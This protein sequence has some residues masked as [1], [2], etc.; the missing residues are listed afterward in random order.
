M[1]H[2]PTIS[3]TASEHVKLI[4]FCFANR[5]SAQSTEQYNFK[6]DMEF[7]TDAVVSDLS[8]N[9]VL[10]GALVDELD[11]VWRCCWCLLLAGQRPKPGHARMTRG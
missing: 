10:A 6:D 3:A 9:P 1:E 11:Q 8:I 7:A 5:A 2:F 4:L